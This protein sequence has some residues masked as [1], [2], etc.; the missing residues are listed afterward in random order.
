MSKRKYLFQFFSSFF[1]EMKYSRQQKIGLYFNEKLCI[2]NPTSR[3]WK[4]RRRFTEENIAKFCRILFS[5][6]NYSERLTKNRD[7]FIFLHFFFHHLF[8]R[9]WLPTIVLLRRL[10]GMI[11]KWGDWLAN[12]ILLSILTGTLFN[13]FL[14]QGTKGSF[15][16]NGCEESNQ[17]SLLYHTLY[18][19]SILDIFYCP[20]FSHKNT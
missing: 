3:I 4:S 16:A 8:I 15:N 19:M 14:P 6:C 10:S 5:S 12:S 18:F 11:S 7:P 17:N 9:T 20:H 2:L 1:Y 13:L